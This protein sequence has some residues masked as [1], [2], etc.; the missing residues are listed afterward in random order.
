MEF[1]FVYC[2]P[3]LVILL[4]VVMFNMCFNSCADLID[5]LYV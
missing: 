5:M 3:L 4:E 2:F 1:A